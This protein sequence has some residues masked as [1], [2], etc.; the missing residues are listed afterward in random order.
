[1][2]GDM[3]MEI[4]LNKTTVTWA[5]CSDGIYHTK[6]N[7]ID[8]MVSRFCPQDAKPWKWHCCVGRGD[9]EPRFDVKGSANTVDEAQ[10]LAITYAKRLSTI[11]DL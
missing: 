11:K 5:L 4:D 9:S 2:N 1:M 10:A 8:C 6:F 7:G 3:I